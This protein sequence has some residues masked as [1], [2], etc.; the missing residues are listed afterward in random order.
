MT[1]KYFE[2]MPKNLIEDALHFAES[3]HKGQTRDDGTPFF[4]HPAMVSQSCV[5]VAKIFGHGH[6]VEACQAVAL[7][8]DVLEDTFVTEDDLLAVFPDGVVRSVVLLTR[9]EHIT[10]DQYIQ[11]MLN[12]PVAC[13]VKVCDI[14]HNLIT[15]SSANVSE[16]RRE[17]RKKKYLYYYDILMDRLKEFSQAV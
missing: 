8:H 7:L 2:I 16:K 5:R 3:A 4:S 9:G 13:I 12:D 14:G 10:Y 1:T 17:K 15:L 6:L 11:K